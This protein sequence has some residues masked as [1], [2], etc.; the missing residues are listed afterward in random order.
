M[1]LTSG[2]SFEDKLLSQGS[3]QSENANFPNLFSGTSVIDASGLILPNNTAYKCY[4]GMFA[5]C[6]SLTKAPELPA[7]TLA[8]SCYSYMFQG[9]S[10]LNYIKCLATTISAS[11]SHY[12]WVS[13]VQTTSGTFVKNSSI[14]E[15]TW[16][17]GVSG[18]PNN[19]T[20]EDA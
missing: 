20:V 19:W 17:R 11:Y 2:S 16:G 6:T 10:S 18:I 9:C 15:S 1:S 12:Y 3:S 4:M 8:E 5:N 14:T 13:G 7:T